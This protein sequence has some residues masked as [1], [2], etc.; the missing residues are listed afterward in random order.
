MATSGTIGTTTIS[1]MKLLEKAVRRCG[2]MPQQLEP[3]IVATAT[4]D[5]FMLLMSLSNRGLNLWCVDQQLMPLVSGKKT[6]VL[7]T[8]TTDVLNL[9]LCTPRSITGDFELTTNYATMPFEDGQSDVVRVGVKFSVLP[10]VSFQIQSSDDGVTWV[11]QKTVTDF[12]E[13]DEFGWYD[14]DVV[15]SATHI[16]L[17][18]T[19]LG[20]VSDIIAASSVRELNIAA[21]NRDDYANQ[22]NKNQ[23]SITPVNYFFEK[24]VTPQITLWPVPS[25]DT[26][27]LS[28]YRYR[29]IQ[30]IGT[31][32]QTIE[33][34]M[35]WFEAICWHLAAR[36]AFE[37]PGV[38]PARR[39]EVVQM[40]NGMT[41]EVEGG[42]TDNSPT[43]F[44]PNIGVYTS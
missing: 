23:Q 1:T 42:E 6:Y 36:L 13:V 19:T 3:E 38:D 22:P 15:I 17:Y 24:L 29:Q 26:A 41:L 20:T 35:R 21:F 27:H 33:L 25:D 2:L 39:A 8:G 34:P 11:T 30:D 28:L 18:S 5:L 10:T 4:E 12:P 43:Y 7:P 37:L 31:L 32:T 40:A 16:R 44:A 9:L 14:L